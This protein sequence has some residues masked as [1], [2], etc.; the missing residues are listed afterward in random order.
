MYIPKRLWKLQK[1]AARMKKKGENQG[2]EWNKLCERI[3]LT[4]L[5]VQDAERRYN[6]RMMQE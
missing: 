5:T 3:T 2:D 4:T 6:E 1:M